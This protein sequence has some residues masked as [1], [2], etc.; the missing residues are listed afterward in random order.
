MEKW[1]HFMGTAL[2]AALL[3]SLPA[4]SNYQL[5]N[6]GFGAGGASNTS[7]PNYSANA[8]SG[9]AS[10]QNSTSTNYVGKSG[11]NETQQANVPP[12]PTF[13]NPSNYYNKLKFVVN[14]GGNPSDAKFAIAISSDNFATTNYVQNDDTVGPTLGAEDYQTYAS[15]GSSSGQT[16]TGLQ[17]STTYKIKIKAT[18][19]IYTET[20]YG[21]TASAATVAP[22]I[23]FDID[24]SATD[25]S[26]NPPYQ[27]NMGN[28]LPG[29][30][31]VAPVGIYIS[32]DT[33]ANSG[34]IV[35]VSSA[36]GGLFSAYANYTIASNTVDLG[37][38]QEGF[39][40]IVKT[41]NQTGG[42][43]LTADSPFLGSGNN[44]GRFTTLYQKILHS[45]G[46]ITGGRGQISLRA[47]SK[48]STPAAA[49]YTDTLTLIA[50]A[51]F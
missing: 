13:T 46:P 17:P 27:V 9:E 33:N 25:Q 10:G 22:S 26:T 38:A 15:W 35:Y 12:A 50:S 51:A 2:A 40:G 14:N 39:G 29:S 28:L 37:T 30:I 11:N 24:V 32:L 49:D 44:V 6:Y 8:L 48:T 1:L 23:T 34:G 41:T 19:G 18:T 3:A 21:P 45:T 7:S 47:K 4:S 42:G 31:T 36:K 43:P 5:N 16:I 20:Q